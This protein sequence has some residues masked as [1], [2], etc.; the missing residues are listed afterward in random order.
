MA[1]PFVA[2][3]T[4]PVAATGGAD[5]ESLESIKARGA[6]QLRHG[7]RAVSA[8]DLQWLARD[9]TP[10]IARARCLSLTGPAGF[11]QRGWVTLL[12]VPYSDEPEPQP[13][14]ETKRRVHDYLARRV[15]VA[16]AQHIRVTGPRYTPIGVRA[17]IVPLQ[18]QEA[19]AVERRVRQNLNQF[20]HPLTG[21]L[22]RHGWQF[23]QEVWLS[24]IARV[25]EETQGVDYV[26][27][28]LLM[29]GG[30]LYEELIP[31]DADGLLAAGDHELKLTVGAR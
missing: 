9:A 23:G 27:Q 17:E 15:P 18:A 28:V 24:Q 6:Q 29:S 12:I 7:G 19:E 10:E 11:A 4:N 25:I 2:S 1:V 30:H 13:S 8:E 31:I 26:S 22:D 14:A 16:L 5:T 20:L 21:G 3:A